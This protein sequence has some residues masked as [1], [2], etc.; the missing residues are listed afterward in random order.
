MF[1]CGN[2]QRLFI[3]FLLGE[4]KSY[5]FWKRCYKSRFPEMYVKALY[6]FDSCSSPDLPWKCI[7]E[8]LTLAILDNFW[9]QI[10]PLLNL[11]ISFWKLS[12]ESK[13][14]LNCFDLKCSMWSLQ[15]ERY[16][17]KSGT[18]TCLHWI[19]SCKPNFDS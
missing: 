16:F 13:Y 2:K 9:V 12:V 3:C 5:L 4:K 10:G 14:V 1:L 7:G 15:C 8:H 17:M 18:L 19:Q 6:K 11:T